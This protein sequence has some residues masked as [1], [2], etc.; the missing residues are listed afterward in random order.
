MQVSPDGKLAA[1]TSD[2]SGG[3]DVWIRDYPVP[4]GKWKVSSTEL[5]G[6]ARWSRDGNYVYFWRDGSAGPDTMYRA[7]VE[8][9]PSVVVHPPERVLTMELLGFENWDLHPDG[10]RIAIVVNVAA[11]QP[12]T[13]STQPV[14]PS[15]YV[16]V[17]NWFTELKR[18][19][20]RA[21]Q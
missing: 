21:K 13:S 20:S 1:F 3:R 6:G 12:A 11:S 19:T 10:K 9:R 14:A 18:L 15:R 5:S 7:R 2:E 16:I 4:Q 8:R 17:Q